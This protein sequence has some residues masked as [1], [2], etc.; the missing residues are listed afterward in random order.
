LTVI[1]FI[2]NGQYFI[3]KGTRFG[4]SP[5]S[6]LRLNSIHNHRSYL[7]TAEALTAIIP[8]NFWKRLAT[9]SITPALIFGKWV[10]SSSNLLWGNGRFEQTSIPK[11]LE[12]VVRRWIST[13]MNISAKTVKRGFGDTLLGCCKLKAFDD[14]PPLNWFRTFAVHIYSLIE[15]PPATKRKFAIL[16]PLRFCCPPLLPMQIRHP[17]GLPQFQQRPLRPCQ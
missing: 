12:R 5:T 7:E 9:S 11:S 4:K 15:A 6:V 2:S 3:H 1:P 10:V 16:S 17:Y 8:L 14:R 13:W